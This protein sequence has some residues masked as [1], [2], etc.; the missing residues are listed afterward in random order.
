ML[1]KIQVSA[2]INMW[3]RVN[4]NVFKTKVFFSYFRT[5]PLP[6]LLKQIKDVHGISVPV[7]IA[8]SMLI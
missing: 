2:R 1:I 6:P 5:R 3:P 8:N 7:Y 4:I